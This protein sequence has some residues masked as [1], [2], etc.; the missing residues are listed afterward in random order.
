[1]YQFK[2]LL[3]QLTVAIFLLASCK[4][5]STTTGNTPDPTPTPV[6]ADVYVTGYEINAAGISVAKLWK[7]GT[8]YDVSDGTKNASASGVFV[9][10]TEVYVCFSEG[11]SRQRAKLWKNGVVSTLYFADINNPFGES[12]ASGMCNGVVSG[13]CTT[14]SGRFVAVYW[15]DNGVHEISNASTDNAGAFAIHIKAI[16]NFTRTSLCGQIDSYTTIASKRAFSW[17][18][19]FSNTSMATIGGTQ[20]SSV[21]R[22]CFIND[23]GFTY[24]GGSEGQ[25]KIWFE[26]GATI[27]PATNT[28]SVN[29][30]YVVG[31]TNLYAVG[32]ELVNGK[33]IAK[34]WN[35][36]YLS[37][38]LQATN[39]SNSQYEA[40]ASA[41]QVVDGNTFI[42]G[43]EF[44]SDG[45]VYAKYWKN[46]T[47]V[48]IGGATSYATAI[49]VVKK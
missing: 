4:K 8:A 29:G 21:G 30:L 44:E 35:G 39:L 40:T 3:L 48:K 37:G 45:K 13:W 16:N 23:N 10:G 38:N 33:H 20:L 9:R 19:Q 25:P 42:A 14:G 43:N 49:Y 46:G 27:T 11:T 17:G 7:N 18:G 28:G 2:H 22:T 1:M 47:A 12:Q 5:N 6:T 32:D 31:N 36:D 24:T 26:N 15:D 34:L 41:I